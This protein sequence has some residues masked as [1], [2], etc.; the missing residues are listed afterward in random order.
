M[1]FSILFSRSFKLQMMIEMKLL[2]SAGDQEIRKSAP[3]L[4]TTSPR[5]RRVKAN[6]QYFEPPYTDHRELDARTE[7]AIEEAVQL[8]EEDTSNTQVTYNASDTETNILSFG[9]D[10]DSDSN[11][12]I[13]SFD[14]A[15]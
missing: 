5:K 11:A 9:S 4:E 6:V 1:R 14:D 2:I 8:D 10:Y 3:V 13:E 15:W 7:R 12:S